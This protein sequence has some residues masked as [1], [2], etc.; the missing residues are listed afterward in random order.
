MKLKT[1][2]DKLLPIKN[3]LIRY[4]VLI[5]IICVVAIFCFMTLLIAHYANLE[6][7][8]FQVEDTKS[9]LRTIKLDDKAVQK[10]NQ[11]Q[12]QN[13][14]IETLFNNGRANPFE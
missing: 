4:T 12:G 13:I 10:I 6:P 1:I 2:L 14:N 5:F 9:S 7:T 3:F 8:E 11:L